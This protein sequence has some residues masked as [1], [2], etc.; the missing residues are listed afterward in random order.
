VD[1]SASRKDVGS[2]AARSLSALP[3]HVPAAQGDFVGSPQPRTELV[4]QGG[5]NIDISGSMPTPKA[6]DTRINTIEMIVA[7]TMNV[8]LDGPER[9]FTRSR[10]GK[11]Q[12]VVMTPSCM[13]FN[14]WNVDEDVYGLD[15]VNER[16]NYDRSE[17]SGV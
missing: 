2:L 7:H 8:R 17:R 10:T 13:E 9:Y 11:C 6:M 5:V 1:F 3:I 4:G 16:A 14:S 12:I 15:G